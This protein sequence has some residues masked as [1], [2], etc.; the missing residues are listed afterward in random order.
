MNTPINTDVKYIGRRSPYVD[1]L[2]GTNLSF[3]RGQVRS[4]PSQIA[5]RFL[6]HADMFASCKDEQAAS[7]QDGQSSAQLVDDTLQTLEQAQK[8][9][10]EQRD[11]DTQRQQLIDQIMNMDKEGVQQFAKDSYNQVVPKNLSLDNMRTKVLS[12]LDQYG[13]C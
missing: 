10:D 13:V 3:E 4:L 11:K 1:R 5:K 6:R 7:S 12:M 2:Y 9:Q 8:L